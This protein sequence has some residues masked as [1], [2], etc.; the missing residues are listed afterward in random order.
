[1]GSVADLSFFFFVS[2]PRDAVT[3]SR[4]FHDPTTV[5]DISTSLPRS[6]DEPA[7]L[8]PSPPFVRS[9]VKCKCPLLFPTIISSQLVFAWCIQHII[10]PPPQDDQFKKPPSRIR[11]TCFWQHDLKAMWGF[12]STSAG[13]QQQLSTM[14]L[15]MFKSVIK[16]GERVPKLGG[17]GH[18]VSIG[19]VRY[20]VDREALTV[21][22]SILP[23]DEEHFGVTAEQVHGVD[24]V[25]V[26]REQ[27]RLT[28]SVECILPSLE[29]WDVLVSAKAS[30]EEV[31]QL[32]WSAHAIRGSSNPSP[33]NTSPPDQIILRLT[34]SPPP[35]DHSV[36]RVKLVIEISGASRG[37]RLNGLPQTIYDSE[38]RDPQSYGVPQAM[39]ADIASAVG[40]SVQT[41]T[42]A[43][44]LRTTGTSV[45]DSKGPGQG[46]MERSPAAEKTILSKVRR[47]YIYF[48]S[49][50]QEPEA[51]WRRST[52][53]PFFILF[54]LI[55]AT[56]R[57]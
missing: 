41:S 33:L 12:G 39:L 19:R 20:Q 6:P 28:R 46:Q 32:P 35:N 53:F 5:I 47:N 57:N 22:Y 17:Y 1:M 24:E 43:S 55:N 7:Y 23:D 51:K 18:G 34:H 29:G 40:L 14:V 25:Q 21:D 27:R 44:S 42:T 52:C 16:R 50:L 10:P 8:R 30:S 15:S 31:E 26:I 13:V 36:L 3:I 56:T 38:P 45:V 2:S 9:H 37:L 4:S 48:S 11:I 49:L 54:L